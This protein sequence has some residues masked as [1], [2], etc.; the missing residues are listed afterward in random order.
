MDPITVL[1]NARDNNSLVPGNVSGTGSIDGWTAIANHG[2]GLRLTIFGLT[3]L[4]L[5]PVLAPALHGQG[6]VFDSASHHFGVVKQ[7]EKRTHEFV[8]RNSAADTAYLAPPKA[9]CGCTAALLSDAIVPPG[10]T[11]KLS[12]TFSAYQGVVGDVTK[13]VHV[14][15]VIDMAEKEIATL[16]ITAHIVGEITIEPSMIKFQVSAGTETV[17][18]LKMTSNTDTLLTLDNISVALMEYI[19]TTAGEMYSAERVISRVLTDFAIETEKQELGPGENTD[20]VLKIRTHDK[21]QINGHI[22]IVL[23]H[24]EI[25]LPVVGVVHRNR[26]PGLQ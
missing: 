19:D 14:S 25:R 16:N 20:L 9:G 23:P 6:I 17:Q 11:G 3:L 24:S 8:F 2:I 26:S 10:G 21:G 13:S 12:V 15:Q 4:F 5:S 7:G 22:R 1:L 18:R